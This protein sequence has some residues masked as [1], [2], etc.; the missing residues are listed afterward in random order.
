MASSNSLKRSI[1]LLLFI[2]FYLNQFLHKNPLVFTE[3]FYIILF[4]IFL[5]D[6]IMDPL[7]TSTLNAEPLMLALLL[8]KELFR[9]SMYVASRTSKAVAFFIRSKWLS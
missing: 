9:I 2:L 8:T 5:P 7:F 1:D 3:K 4:S 6:M